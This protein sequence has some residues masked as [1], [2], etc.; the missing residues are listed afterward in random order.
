MAMTRRVAAFIAVSLMWGLGC[1]NAGE[2][3]RLVMKCTFAMSDAEIAPGEAFVYLLRDSKEGNYVVVHGIAQQRE[4]L[5]STEMKNGGASAR[6]PAHPNPQ[7]DGYLW[8]E[9]SVGAE[10]TNWIAPP[11]KLDEPSITFGVSHLSSNAYPSC[12]ARDM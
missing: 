1:G 6:F 11:N 8:K 2:E 12:L 7:A 4:A 5:D 3:L 9:Q 10:V